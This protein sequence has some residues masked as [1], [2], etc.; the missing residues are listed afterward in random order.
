MPMLPEYFRKP[1]PEQELSACLAAQL[2]V[3][4]HVEAEQT[5]GI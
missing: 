5:T 4:A 2:P 3:G 1:P